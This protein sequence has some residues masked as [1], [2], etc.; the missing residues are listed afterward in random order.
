V[1]GVEA[2]LQVITHLISNDGAWN[3]FWSRHPPSKAA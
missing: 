3:R 2:A 1:P